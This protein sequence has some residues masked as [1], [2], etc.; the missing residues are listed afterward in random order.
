MCADDPN[1]DT[2]KSGHFA[3]LMSTR[4]NLITLYCRFRFEVPV[5]NSRHPVQ[6]LQIGGTNTWNHKSVLLPILRD[7]HFVASSG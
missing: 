1:A 4:P 2:P 6:E 7:G 5:A 3:R